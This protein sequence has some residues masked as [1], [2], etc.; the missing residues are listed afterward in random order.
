MKYVGSPQWCRLDNAAK[1][2]PSTSNARDTKVFRF[3][4][5]LTEPVNP[6]ALQDALD[7][8]VEQFPFYRSVLK[9]GLFWYYFEDSPLRPAVRKEDIPPCAPIYSAD[10]KS[11][12][13][14]VLYYGSRISLEVYHALSDGTGALHFLRMLVYYYLLAVHKETFSEN[15]PLF[16]Y[17]ASQTQKRDDSFRKYFEKPPFPHVSK[18]RDAYHLRGGHLPDNRLG[19]VEGTMPLK[20]LLAV[21]HDKGVT[22]SEL[23]TAV[24]IRS[25][26]AGM[27]LQ[28]CARPVVITVP[29]NLRNYFPSESARNFFATVNVEYDF[30]RQEDTLEAVCAH[31]KQ[32]FRDSLTADGL[33]MRMN[34][35]GALEHSLPMKLIPLLLKDPIL[36]VANLLA[37]R[38]ITAAFSNIG[39]ISM[40]EG[41]DRYI[42]L[43]DAFISTNRLQACTCSF[44]G[45]F[46]ISFTAPFLN[47]DVQREFFRSLTGFGIPAEITTNLNRLQ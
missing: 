6:D 8:T 5:E 35:L 23:L 25:I 39:R 31:V 26:H 37:E 11:L 33:R 2:F 38:K 36:R 40:P 21:S 24:L 9:K 7:K 29:V 45:N 15:P 32:C 18:E 4:C 17:D 27:S 34:A 41:M 16:D 28:D 13:F 22:L 44:G 3:A 47:P 20:A 42:R 46:V 10:C 19:V 30:R 43:F 12:L 1:I 14:R